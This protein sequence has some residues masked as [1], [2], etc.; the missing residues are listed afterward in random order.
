MVNEQLGCRCELRVQCE[1]LGLWSSRSHLHVTPH[2]SPVLP[3]G[4]VSG[5][6]FGFC[7]L[8][9]ISWHT[10]YLASRWQG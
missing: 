2:C 7:K 4:L 5:F 1:P 6:D 10:R 3:K 9:Q 8:I